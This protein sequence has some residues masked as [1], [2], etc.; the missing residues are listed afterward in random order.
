MNFL[1]YLEG[2]RNTSLMIVCSIR[3]ED[4]TYT[5]TKL[6]CQILSILNIEYVSVKRNVIEN[7]CCACYDVMTSSRYSLEI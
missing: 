1:K 2:K 3:L 5:K 4:K 6:N 7:S